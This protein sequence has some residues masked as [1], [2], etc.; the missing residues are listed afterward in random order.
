MSYRQSVI[1]SVATGANIANN[2]GLWLALA[3]RSPKGERAANDA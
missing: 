1:G 2:G 3:A